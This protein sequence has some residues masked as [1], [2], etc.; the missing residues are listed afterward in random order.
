MTADPNAIAY[1]DAEGRLRFRHVCDGVLR[2]RPLPMSREEG[3]YIVD[4]RVV[5]SIHCT[6]CGTHEFY[7][8]SPAPT[9]P[10][11]EGAK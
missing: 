9:T 10:D 8:L 5:P 6:S 4:G 11:Q 3:W 1:L 7:A 2:D